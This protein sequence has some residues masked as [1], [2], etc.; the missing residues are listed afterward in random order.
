MTR[1]NPQITVDNHTN[2]DNSDSNECH[3]IQPNRRNQEIDPLHRDLQATYAITSMRLATHDQDHGLSTPSSPSNNRI[4]ANLDIS[5]IRNIQSSCAIISESSDEEFA[6]SIFT[7]N[8]ASSDSDTSGTI[9]NNEGNEVE[10]AINNQEV[11]DLRRQVFGQNL[12]AINEAEEG[13][14]E[15]LWSGAFMDDFNKTF[16][17]ITGNQEEED[18]CVSLNADN[19]VTDSMMSRLNNNRNGGLDTWNYHSNIDECNVEIDSVNRYLSIRY[20]KEVNRVVENV[21]T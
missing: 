7:E 20:V 8:D 21:K 18:K 15:D 2:L 10:H 5:G 14:I 11:I 4:P 3:E 16:D 19:S 6:A 9:D 17:S 12:Q 13:L 1:N